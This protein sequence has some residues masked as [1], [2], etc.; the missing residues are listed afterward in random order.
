M[1]ICFYSMFVL[2]CV[3]SCFVTG[4][5]S[6]QATLPIKIKNAFFNCLNPSSCTMVLRLTQPLTEMRTRN[7]PGGKRRPAGRRLS[8]TVSRPSFLDNVTEFLWKYWGKL[9]KHFKYPVYKAWLV[10][11]ISR[12][13]NKESSMMYCNI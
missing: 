10:P 2:S 5:S 4:W 7:L 12:R 9:L 13:Q 8:Q 1:F 6:I 3:G 11:G